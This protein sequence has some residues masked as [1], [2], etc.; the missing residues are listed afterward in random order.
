MGIDFDTPL[1]DTYIPLVRQFKKAGKQPRTRPAV[2]RQEA[3]Q[4]AEVRR[5]VD[6]LAFGYQAQDEGPAWQ[7]PG[8][9]SEC[10]GELHHDEGRQPWR[11][12]YTKTGRIDL[13]RHEGGGCRAAMRRAS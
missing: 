12:I 7:G 5:R 6:R 3:L 4:A 9:C 8:I 1:A 2:N 13:H 11:S 10:G